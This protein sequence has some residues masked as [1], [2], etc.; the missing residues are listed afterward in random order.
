M[1]KAEL[2]G[3]TTKP[4]P[5]QSPWSG[6]SNSAPKLVFALSRLLTP[7]K[8][9]SSDDADVITA[10]EECTSGAWL[11]ELVGW[12]RRVPLGW[13]EP[14]ATTSPVIVS[15]FWVNDRKGAQ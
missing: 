14:G 5:T 4:L 3:S 7:L 1:V 12:N 10:D 11:N 6:G 8:P 2:T 13:T 15:F 9:S